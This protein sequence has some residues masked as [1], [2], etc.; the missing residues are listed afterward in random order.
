MEPLIADDPVL[1]EAIS[2][3]K[4]ME[5]DVSM[6]KNLK[7]RLQ[8]VSSFLKEEREVAVRVNKALAEFDDIANNPHLDQITRTQIWNIVSQLEKINGQ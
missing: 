6:P 2:S 4:E 5:C 1:T 7:T 8:M 3:L